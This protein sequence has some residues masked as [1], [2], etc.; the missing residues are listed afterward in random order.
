[1]LYSTV[2]PLS[3]GKGDALIPTSNAF[4]GSVL[5][6]AY[7]PDMN[8]SQFEGRRVSFPMTAGGLEI[9]STFDRKTYAP[10]E[11][12]I[13]NLQLRDGKRAAQEGLFGVT[14]F[15][16]AVEERA[17][18]D[19]EFGGRYSVCHRCGYS[20]NYESALP[21]LTLAD[22]H[23]IDR[24]QPVPA[25]LELA[26]EVL[27]LRWFGYDEEPRT[28]GDFGS[29]AWAFPSFAVQERF[30]VLAHSDRQPSSFYLPADEPSL[31]EIVLR[32]DPEFDS[33]RDP[34][35]NA[36]RLVSSV[37]HNLNQIEVLSAGADEIFKSSDDFRVA[38]IQWPYFSGYGKTVGKAIAQYHQRTSGYVRDLQTFKE[39]IRRQGEEFDEWRDPLGRPYAVSFG[40]D[41]HR[42]TVDIRSQDWVLWREV[43]DY[44]AELTPRI[45]AALNQFVLK[46]NRVPETDSELR[47]ILRDAGISDSE[48]MDPWKRAYYFVQKVESGYFDSVTV[49]SGAQSGIRIIPVTQQSQVLRLR[50]AGPDGI[51]GTVD[52]FTAFS[53]MRP[54]SE[55]SVEQANPR[56][57]ESPFL[58]E[59]FG[60]VYGVVVDSSGALIPGVSVTLT[61]PTGLEVVALTA[62]DGH[63]LIRNLDSGTYQIRFGLPGFQRKVLTGV[64][65]HVGNITRVV[66][67]LEV[68][69]SATMV[70]VSIDSSSGLLATSS[71]SIGEV[72]VAGSRALQPLSTPRLREY[73]PETLLWQPAVK[74]G[75]DGRAQ[76]RFKLADSMTT[77]KAVAIASTKDGRIAV[78][79][80]DI[81]A[82]QP[83]FV[84]HDPPKLLTEGD[85][86]DLPVVVRSYLDRDQSV[87]LSMKSEDWFAPLS[88]ASRKVSVK[89]G[90]FT[91]EVFSFKALKAVRDGRQ[92]VTALGSEDSDAIEKSST[93]YPFGREMTQV[94]SAIFRG[95]SNHTL[96]IPGDALPGSVRAE[97]KIYPNLMAHVVDAIEGIMQRPYGCA[98]QVISSAYPSLLYLRH[99]KQAGRQAD[100]LS[101]KAKRYLGIALQTLHGYQSG[102]GGFSYWTRGEPDAAVTAYAL[103]FMTEAMDFVDVDE[104]IAWQAR[105]W[106]ANK[107]AADGSWEGS[108]TLTAYIAGVLS[109]AGIRDA[110]KDPVPLALTYLR[111]FSSQPSEPYVAA[112]IALAALQSGDSTL[113]D[114]ALNTLRG[115]LRA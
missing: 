24:K 70:E 49:T 73:F 10:G 37:F 55:H 20:F 36:Y 108:A 96:T 104:D 51:E 67:T 19:A 56:F 81:V 29:V 6:S 103:Q 9:E 32:L 75:T 93:V 34:W 113:A 89:A 114:A 90:E 16:K 53:F 86:I 80:M 91:K 11:E 82:F 44:T 28:I 98:E 38:L 30:T 63:F 66:A 39:E 65:V 100:P 41:R 23:R 88:N 77:W 84:E 1:V 72:T 4:S 112:S 105:L 50:S 62:D 3:A 35:D 60:T 7:H 106:L 68:A 27:L 2:L 87:D 12:A 61:G 102:E 13:L 31:R 79:E 43:T 110:R 45:D 54:V 5:I 69:R 46:Q 101:Q 17:Q 76:V 18:T 59:T 52:D 48:L 33:L 94:S 8:D 47:S 25:D 42:F 64:Y 92:R 71:A 83:F 95:G 14:V 111:K 109:A 107:Q 115:A 21:G 26:A 97:L 78:S 22:L 58:D 15:D 57:V 40:I 99:S 74:T 85:Q